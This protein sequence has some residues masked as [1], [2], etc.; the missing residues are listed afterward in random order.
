MKKNTFSKDWIRGFERA[1][2]LFQ[3]KR[4]RWSNFEWDLRD[5]VRRRLFG[6]KRR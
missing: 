6:K 2:A 5:R 1:C 3:A 4:V